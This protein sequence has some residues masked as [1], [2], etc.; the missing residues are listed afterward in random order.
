MPPRYPQHAALLAV[1]LLI[2]CIASPFSASVQAKDKKGKSASRSKSFKRSFAKR[3]KRRSKNAD[4]ESAAIP[5]TYPIAPDHV[6]VIESGE[7]TASDVSRHLNP[8][9]PRATQIQTTDPDLSAPKQRKN[10]KIDGS[11]TLQIQQALKQ[12]GFYSGELTGVYDKDTI[13]A[14]RRFQIDEKIPTTGY[15]T[16]HALKRLGLGNW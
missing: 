14:M 7:S 1:A 3:G 5:A 15:P 4:Y 12:R 16:A 9:L 10:V 13:E 2:V 11:R 6:E 8:P